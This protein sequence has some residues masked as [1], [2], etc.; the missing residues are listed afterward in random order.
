MELFAHRAPWYVAGPLMGILIVGLRAAANRPF[1]ALGGYIDVAENAREPSRLGFRSFLLLGFL[2]GGLLF[3]VLTGQF[4][5]TLSYGAIDRA[6]APGT[7]LA[8][9]IG[10]GALMGFGARRAGGCTSGHGMCGMSLG[11]PASFVATL[12]F[13]VTG[14]ALAHLLSL[15][16]L[17]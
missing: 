8:L 10:S 1:G 3:A 16:G 9:L 13:L 17:S 2:A 5:L 14:V 6:F 11:S 12:T 15:M 4:H 7:K